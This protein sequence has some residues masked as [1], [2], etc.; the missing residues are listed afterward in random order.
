[1]VRELTVLPTPSELWALSF[2]FDPESEG[3]AIGAE[4]GS[5]RSVV[6]PRRL[7]HITQDLS[8]EDLPSPLDIS[9]GMDVG[10]RK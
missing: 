9:T 3:N 7:L 1:M 8:E 4:E 2:L 6:S 5:F 10:R